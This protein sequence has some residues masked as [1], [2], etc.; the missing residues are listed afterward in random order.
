MMKLISLSF[1]AIVFS[2]AVA[3]ASDEAVATGSAV[4]MSPTAMPT[5]TAPVETTKAALSESEIPLNVDVSKKATET[6]AGSTRIFL[7]VFVLMSIIGVSYYM[8]R[9]YKLSNNI[10]KSNTRIKV[11]SQH[12]LGPKKSLAIIHV[13]GESMLI[14]VTDQKFR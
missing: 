3:L 10:N 11:L 13:A 14:G 4:D 12:Y 8:V 6:A 7:T 9:K 1:L 5:V 2:A